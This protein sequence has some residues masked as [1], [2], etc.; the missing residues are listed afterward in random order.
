MSGLCHKYPR[1][2]FVSVESGFGWMPSFIECM[3]WQ[4]LNSGA[5]KAFPEQEIPSFTSGA[6]VRDVLVRER[7]GRAHGHLPR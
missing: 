5:A 2:K 6:S 4:W 7:G 1:L 3:D